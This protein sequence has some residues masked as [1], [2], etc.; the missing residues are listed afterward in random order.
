[1]SRLTFYPELKYPSCRERQLYEK[2]VITTGLLALDSLQRMCPLTM[3]DFL[4]SFELLSQFLDRTM[5]ANSIDAADR[6]IV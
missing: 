6:G 4:L 5:S 1:M 2:W 3:L